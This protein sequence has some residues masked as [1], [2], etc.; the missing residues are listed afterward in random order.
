MD[1]ANT[2][3]IKHQYRGSTS[4]YMSNICKHTNNTYG[5]TGDIPFL[6]V[7]KP[8]IPLQCPR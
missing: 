6:E 5:D 3:N 4:K 2:A 8:T 7:E 1:E